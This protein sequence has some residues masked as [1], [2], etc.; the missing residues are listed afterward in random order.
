[1]AMKTGIYILVNVQTQ[2]VRDLTP[3]QGVNSNVVNLDHKFPDQILSRNEPER[4]AG[5]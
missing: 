4:S 2:V 3:F 1:M 5:F